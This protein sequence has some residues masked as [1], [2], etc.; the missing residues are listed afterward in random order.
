MACEPDKKAAFLRTLNVLRAD[1]IHLLE[2]H[3]HDIPD[4]YW[5]PGDPVTKT[6]PRSAKDRSR[7]KVCLTVTFNSDREPIFPPANT[8]LSDELVYLA[9]KFLKSRER[10]I[11]YP[12]DFDVKGDIDPNRIPS[13]VAPLVRAH[14]LP[15][16]PVYKGYYVLCG[17][18][19]AKWIG[20]LLNRKDRATTGRFP[21]WTIG[22]VVAPASAVEM[23]RTIERQLRVHKA[24]TA[25]HFEKGEEGRVAA[26]DVVST[27]HCDLSV[28]PRTPDMSGGYRVMPIYQVLGY[29][30]QCGPDWDE[31]QRAAVVDRRVFVEGGVGFDYSAALKKPLVSQRCSLAEPDEKVEGS[32]ALDESSP[33]VARDPVHHKIENQGNAMPSSEGNTVKD[34]ASPQAEDFIKQVQACENE[35]NGLARTMTDID[36]DIF[37]LRT[38]MEPVQWWLDFTQRSVRALKSEIASVKQEAKRSSDSDL[39]PRKRLKTDTSCARQSEEKAEEAMPISQERTKPPRKRVK[40]DTPCAGRIGEKAGKT[41]SISPGQ[42]KPSLDASP[43]IRS[44]AD[45]PLVPLDASQLD[46]KSE[47][48][49]FIPQDQTQQPLDTSPEIQSNADEPQQPPYANQ[50]EDKAKQAMSTSQ[51]QAKPCLDASPKIQGIADIPLLPPHTENTK[52]STQDYVSESVSTEINAHE[53]SPTLDLPDQETKTVTEDTE[54]VMDIQDPPRRE[55]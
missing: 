6:P 39:P 51:E 17:R 46:E 33:G 35:L 48:A 54:M 40:K 12:Y 14:G 20:W 36:T 9:T 32:G 52:I 5:R 15:F 1:C 7:L 8:R 34:N 42:A 26:R 11:A 2:V 25:R 31:S 3:E 43:E 13:G 18:K 27:C 22:P 41:M 24:T 4:R 47:E 23:S 29:S 37:D 38:K 21:A 30:V 44:S 10:A 55:P 19:H 28:V 45:E 49:T 53:A 16:F 50:T